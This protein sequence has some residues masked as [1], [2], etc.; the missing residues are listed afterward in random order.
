MTHSDMFS[1]WYVVLFFVFVI[2]ILVTASYN[3]YETLRIK[4]QV[5]QDLQESQDILIVLNVVS[6]ILCI[7]L[8]IGYYFSS[9]KSIRTPVL[10]PVSPS[11]SYPFDAYP[12]SRPYF[13]P[14]P[15]DVKK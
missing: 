6:I 2:V 14:Y 7:I 3:L 4:S 13:G 10:N 15:I 5:P 9:D 12:T 11:C 8:L 1:R